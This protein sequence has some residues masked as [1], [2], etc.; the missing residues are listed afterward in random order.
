MN[1]ADFDAAAVDYDQTFTH[2]MVGKAQRE[3]V[4]YYLQQ[5]PIKTGS[6][7]LEVNCGTG[8]DAKRWHES[9]YSVIASDI[10]SQ[11]IANAQSKY[12]E[13]DFRVLNLL[14]LDQLSTEPQTVFSNFGGLNCLPESDLQLFFQKASDLLA[15]NERLVCVLM[16]KK[17]A[18]DRW[19]LTLKGRFSERN[20][21]NTNEALSVPVNG[22]M[23]STWYYSPKET[24]RLANPHFEVEMLRPIG[25]FV[26][27]S[28]MESFFSNK[29][30]MLRFLIGMD[31]RFSFS[32]LA[33]RSDHYFLS[34]KK[35]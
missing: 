18:W 2:T 10:S 31:K 33:N 26:P 35:R 34:L 15:T 23:V 5:L 4:W 1:K 8:E 11:M 32:F 25:L 21:R 16:G 22:T 17:T 30:R 12:P 9:G 24:I 28:N 27:T 7:V 14:E 20:R 6:K 29:P 13:I 19:Y 3:R